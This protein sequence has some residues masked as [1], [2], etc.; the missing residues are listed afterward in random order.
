VT[1]Y[2]LIPVESLDSA[3]I[4]HVRRIYEAGFA[5]HLRSGFESL[6]GGRQP[7]EL[8]LALTADGQPCGFAMLRPLGTTGWIFLRYFVVDAERRGRGLGGILWDQLTSRLRESGYS[9][10]AFDV[11]DPAEPDCGQEESHIRS[12]RIRFYQRHGACL[13]PVTGY[14][15]PHS[16]PEQSDDGQSGAGPSDWTPMLLMA[17]TLGGGDDDPAAVGAIVA[18]VYRHRWRLPTDHPQVGRTLLTKG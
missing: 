3:G 1:S 14:A 5:A 4:D 18:A 11:E 2:H 10:L 7:G 12:R 13:L 6:V 9:L 15:T 17:A 8:P 16:D